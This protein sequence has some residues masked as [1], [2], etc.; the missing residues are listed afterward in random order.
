MML[1][2]IT[3]PLR[4]ET[5]FAQRKSS[6]IASLITPEQFE[7]LLPLACAWAKEQE[8]V[9]ASHGVPL[10]P[11]QTND[12]NNAGVLLP[13]KVRLWAVPEI[14]KPAHP[15]LNLAA[16]ATGLISPLTI[17]LTLRYGIFIRA[18]HWGVRRLVVHELVHTAQYERLGGFESFLR[19]YL[20]ECI[21]IGY[22][23]APL[24]QEAKRIES[25]ICGS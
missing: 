21:R 22:P 1:S 5:P 2:A 14:P 13:E 3:A 11:Q 10:S 23:A 12:A 24:E 6:C 20:L 9:I 18:D 15:A 8:Q 19:Q 16:E 4:I 25:R 17:G 7:A